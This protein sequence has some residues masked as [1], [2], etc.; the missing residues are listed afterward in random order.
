MRGSCHALSLALT[1]LATIADATAA[2]AA[3]LSIYD[4]QYTTDAGGASPYY[5]QIQDIAGGVVTHIWFGYNKRVYLQD[6]SQTTWGAIVVKDGE[7]G[8]LANNV[9]VGDWVSFTNIYVDEFGGTT[10]LQY[11]RT[12]A[13]NVSFTVESTGNAVPAPTLLTAADIPY[14]I[15]HEATEPYESMVVTLEHVTVGQMDLGG[16]EDNYEL[17]QGSDLAWATD[18]MNTDAGGP[19]DPRIATGAVLVSITGIVEQN[20]FSP[21]DYFQLN[22]RSAADVVPF[23]YIPAVSEWGLMIMLLLGLTAGTVIFRRGLALHS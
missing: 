7:G 2:R 22:T 12:V 15:N 16:H 11:R 3:G 17:I 6:P 13:P 8:E 4:V 5:G 20:S 10:F 14:P 9:N 23:A 1:V 19:Y 21:W 18:Y